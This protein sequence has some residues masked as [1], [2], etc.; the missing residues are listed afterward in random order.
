MR[1]SSG[2]VISGMITSLMTRSNSLRVEQLDRLGAAGAGDRLVIEL[3]ERADGRGADPRIV[4]DQQDPGAG[5]VDVGSRARWAAGW[6]RTRRGGLGARQI[7][8]DGRALADLALD[9]DLA[10]RLVGEAED[11]AEAEAGALADRL[12][13]EEGLERALDAPRRSCRS[14]CR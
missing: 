4:L 1:I 14:R 8:R 10:A 7:E 2:P 11:L 6:S 5:D 12:G 13:G 3:L 9:P